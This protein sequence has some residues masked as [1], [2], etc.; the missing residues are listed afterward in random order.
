VPDTRETC[1]LLAEPAAGRE[2][3]RRIDESCSQSLD[4]TR[5]P[6]IDPVHTSGTRDKVEVGR[7]ASRDSACDWLASGCSAPPSSV[8]RRRTNHAA[9]PKSLSAAQ[10][11]IGVLCHSMHRRHVRKWHVRDVTPTA[12]RAVAIKGAANIQRAARSCF[13][14]DVVHLKHFREVTHG[15]IRAARRRS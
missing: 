13:V 11:A 8:A 12:S 5:V 7:F 3:R 2:P 1:T 15:G 4:A 9:A 10:P 14:Q 6:R